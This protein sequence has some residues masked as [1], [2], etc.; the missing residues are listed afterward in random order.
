M[1]VGAALVD[2]VVTISAFGDDVATTEVPL[3][4]LARATKT[5]DRVARRTGP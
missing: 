5:I 4:Q 2:V 1:D 3:A